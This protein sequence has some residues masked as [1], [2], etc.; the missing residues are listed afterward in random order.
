MVTIIDSEKPISIKQMKMFEKSIGSNLPDNYRT[1]LFQHNGGK[2]TPKRFATKDGKV[3][4]MVSKFFPLSDQ[5]PDNLMDE[6][7]GFN[8]FKQLPANLLSIAQDPTGNRIVISCRGDDI[9]AIYY[10]SWDEEPTP[11]TCSYDYMRLIAHSFNDF[12]S[13]LK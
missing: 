13:I 2:P 6:F 3:E 9:G 4:S 10:W 1:F 11:P 5:T 8:L 12:V 7:K